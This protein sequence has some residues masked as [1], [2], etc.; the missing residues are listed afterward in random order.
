M[1]PLQLGIFAALTAVVNGLTAY[2]C[3]AGHGKVSRLDL[4]EPGPCP[5][6]D[7]IYRKEEPVEVQ[8]LQ[9]LREQRIMGHACEVTITR[10]LCHCQYARHEH[11]GCH[12]PVLDRP[13]V[14]TAEDC[15]EMV[16]NKTLT[17][18]EYTL[19]NLT[20]GSRGYSAWYS[21]GG[22]SK[23]TA[24]CVTEAFEREG[25]KHVHKYELTTVKWTIHIIAGH[26]DSGPLSSGG[27]EEVV[28]PG[29]NARAPV[30]DEQLQGPQGPIIWRKPRSN[31][32]GLM[33]Q[34]Y[35]GPAMMRRMRQ[36]E[37]ER[38][39]EEMAL[40]VVN[41]ELAE[42]KGLRSSF[43]FTL[44]KAHAV[45][46]LQGYRTNIPYVRAIMIRPG[47]AGLDMGQETENQDLPHLVDLVDQPTFDKSDG[48]L[49]LENQFSKVWTA[50]CKAQRDA[51]QHKLQ[52]VASGN[53]YALLDVLGRGVAVAKAGS[54]AHVITCGKVEASLRL[55]A[56]GCFQ[57]IPVHAIEQD[58]GG[59]VIHRP[60]YMDSLSHILID[61][62]TTTHC[63]GRLPLA[64][65]V[66]DRW[67]CTTGSGL[68]EC[69]P[70]DQLNPAESLAT[71]PE[72]RGLNVRRQRDTVSQEARLIQER[73]LAQRPTAMDPVEQLIQA[74][75]LP[76]EP[77]G[78]HRRPE[79]GSEDELHLLDKLANLTKP[80]VKWIIT[81]YPYLW[82]AGHIVV[83]IL[84]IVHSIAWVIMG[85]QW[86]SARGV[87]KGASLPSPIPLSDLERTTDSTPRPM[88]TVPLPTTEEHNSTTRVTS[89]FNSTDHCRTR[90]RVNV[91]PRIQ[92]ISGRC[93]RA[94]VTYYSTVNPDH[95]PQEADRGTRCHLE[96]NESPGR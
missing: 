12:E 67:Y 19:V 42:E 87:A 59:L 39:P 24:H 84:V 62:P 25:T 5:T 58:P 9:T 6:V 30:E 27:R 63:D 2:N 8:I 36:P 49:Q 94:D 79:P 77:E 45:C 83:F 26:A 70:P 64:Y 57:Q 28:F 4:S 75:L 92:S 76:R 1:G 44:N 46:T 21:H 68:I 89:V 78:E 38:L 11:F 65:Q 22:Y 15:Q 82:A 74:G 51:L 81:S 37:D 35:K 71:A 56:M 17:T 16:D 40:I 10:K 29:L 34:L 91:R 55:N 14:I 60:T 47:D 72:A 31:C 85:L 43:G 80:W 86:W 32:T 88:P 73:I 90:N 3:S 66:E 13:V 69:L 53:P 48:T 93:P 52:A 23:E 18:P 61:Q 41:V 54:A 50:V 20:T 33:R 96:E 95:H 7:D